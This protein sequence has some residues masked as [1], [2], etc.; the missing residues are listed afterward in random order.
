MTKQCPTC[1]EIKSFDMFY[2]RE[3]RAEDGHG[4]RCID[5]HKQYRKDN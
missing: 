5:C 4:H 2:K 3:N 1:K